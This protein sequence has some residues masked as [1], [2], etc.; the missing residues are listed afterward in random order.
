MMSDYPYEIVK[1]SCDIVN[2]ADTPV[3]PWTTISRT[4]PAGGTTSNTI[5]TPAFISMDP[6]IAK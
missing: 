5:V 1:H 4:A 2:K 6:T 3:R